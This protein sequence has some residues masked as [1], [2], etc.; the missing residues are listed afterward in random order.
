MLCTPENSASPH[1]LCCK[2]HITIPEI[3][4]HLL[5]PLNIF[6]EYNAIT[7]FFCLP[8]LHPLHWGN[9]TTIFLWRDI[10]PTPTII[11]VGWPYTRK[12]IETCDPRNQNSVTKERKGVEEGS[13]IPIVEPEKPE[14]QK[15][16]KSQK[17]IVLT[18]TIPFA[19]DRSLLLDTLSSLLSL[20]FCFPSFLQINPPLLIPIA[21][22]S[23]SQFL[24][25]TIRVSS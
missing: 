16:R 2:Q 15:N 21:Q 5:M 1:G 17:I 25:L 19:V 4:P 14:N 18:T 23:Q 11:S 7:C 8:H 13:L 10:L 24:Q 6:I 3:I 12:A 22:V 9:G 20:M